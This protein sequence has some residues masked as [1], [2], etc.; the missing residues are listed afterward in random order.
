MYRMYLQ[1]IGTLRHLSAAAL[2]LVIL[3]ATATAATPGCA[4]SGAKVLLASK[5]ARVYSLGTTLYGCT[6]GRQ[7]KLGALKGTTAAP[8]TRITRYLLAARYV[9]FDTVDMGV[10]TFSSTVT[11]IDLVNGVRADSPAAPS[12]PR[13]ESFKTA[14]AMV[15]DADGIV[16]WIGQSSAIGQPKPQYY[17][18]ALTATASFGQQAT[19]GN[20]TALRLSGHQLSWRNGPSGPTTTKTIA[21][22]PVHSQLH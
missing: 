15:I 14:T 3:A 20:P 7:T 17:V 6:D 13:P 18:R 12:S 19:A 1:R 4:P 9:A 5:L 21:T 10:D 11:L 2:A 8:A 22:G 16:A